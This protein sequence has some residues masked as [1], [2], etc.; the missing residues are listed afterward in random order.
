MNYKSERALPKNK[1]NRARAGLVA[2][3]ALL[4]LTVLV[5]AFTAS[6]AY[7]TLLAYLGF[8]L[9]DYEGEAAIATHEPDSEK[10]AE[11]ARLFEPLLMDNVKLTEFSDARQVSAAYRDA[12]LNYLLNSHYA[13][14]TGNLAL[15]EAAEKEYPHYHITTLIPR[16][17]FESTVYQYF[18][19]QKSIKNESGVLFRY[20]DKVKAYTLVGQP[21]KY[22]I[23]VVVTSCVETESTYRVQFY[24]SLDGEA[25]PV[26]LAVVV[27][28]KD[29]THYIRTLKKVADERVTAPSATESQ[30]NSAG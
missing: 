14:Y 13:K 12:I 11:L 21:V 17:D 9:H 26:Y 29:G 7:R 28:R 15:L 25:S 16:T 19:G 18:G 1:V 20:L 2:A 30:L 8:D 27:K 5:V 3:I 23:Q 22:N 10:A 4:L 6:G 24:N